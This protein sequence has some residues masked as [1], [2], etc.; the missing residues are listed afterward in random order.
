MRRWCCLLL[1]LAFAVPVA[2]DVK[3]H[4]LFTD[5]MVLQQGTKVP[6]WGK[7]DPGEKVTVKFQNQTVAATA[8][9]DGKWMVSLES[10][11]AGGPFEMQLIGKNE[12][13]L[14]DV[15]V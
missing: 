10:L 12:V 6:V 3:P 8:D 2:A 11:K 9:Q 7:A 15:L 14:K 13:T 1:V 4:G 5:H